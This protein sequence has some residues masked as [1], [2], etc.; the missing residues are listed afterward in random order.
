MLCFR[1]SVIFKNLLI[2]LSEKHFPLPIF[3]SV[4]FPNILPNFTPSS[5]QFPLKAN[6]PDLYFYSHWEHNIVIWNFFISHTWQSY[7]EQ[8][9]FLWLTS[10]TWYSA[11]SYTLQ[12]IEWIYLFL[13][14]S[15]PCSIYVYTQTI[16]YSHLFMD[17]WVVPIF[18]VVYVEKQ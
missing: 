8:F 16:L 9:F 7:S 15:I 1:S 12:Q 10:L 17:I 18:W 14:P 4:L 13:W 2:I 5:F 3:P 6:F 11:D